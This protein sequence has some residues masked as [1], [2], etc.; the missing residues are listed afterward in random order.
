MKKQIPNSGKKEL[1]KI[2]PK[3]AMKTYTFLVDYQLKLRLRNW[4]RGCIR[5]KT[6]AA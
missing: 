4:L 6:S 2:A 5:I 1:S 3:K